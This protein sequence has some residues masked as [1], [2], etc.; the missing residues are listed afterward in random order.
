MPTQDVHAITAHLQSKAA[1]KKP[2]SRKASDRATREICASES[3]EDPPALVTG[4]KNTPIIL[5]QTS[6]CLIVKIINAMLAVVYV[7]HLF[8]GTELF[9]YPR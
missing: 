7:L 3:K 8:D 9:A 6:L 4:V 2:L 1:S 5:F